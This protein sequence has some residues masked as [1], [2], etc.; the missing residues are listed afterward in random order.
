MIIERF[1]FFVGIRLY[2]ITYN[3]QLYTV[4]MKKGIFGILFV[5]I[6]KYSDKYNFWHKHTGEGVYLWYYDKEI[7]HLK[8]DTDIDVEKLDVEDIIRYAPDII[9]LVFNDFE[10]V[11]NKRYE[12]QKDIAKAKAWDGIVTTEGREKNAGSSCN[13]TSE[14]EKCVQNAVTNFSV[15]LLAEV[16]ECAKQEDSPIYEGDKEV[17]QWVRLSDVESA[18]SKCSNDDFSGEMV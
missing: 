11:K 9:S 15:A 12:K 16:A 17:D 13:E 5:F 3:N 6:A 7:L 4:K 10:E 14:C 1:H 8:T 18:I 2:P